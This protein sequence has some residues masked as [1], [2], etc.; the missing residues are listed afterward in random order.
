MSFVLVSVAFAIVL[1]YGSVPMREQVWAQQRGL[2]LPEPSD[3]PAPTN[4]T[5]STSSNITI[6]SELKD[7]LNMTSDVNDK[8]KMLSEPSSNMTGTEA[9]QE[10]SSQNES[11]QDEGSDKQSQEDN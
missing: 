8:D 10:K 1:V 4:N 11:E 9:S 6:K 2:I 3:V 5:N 7:N